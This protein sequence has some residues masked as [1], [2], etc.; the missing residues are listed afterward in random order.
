M[1]VNITQVIYMQL[2]LGKEV[3]FLC[4]GYEIEDVK[5]SQ[6]HTIM[7]S[8]GKGEPEYC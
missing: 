8:G 2:M 1:T 3:I 5:A 4:S 7:L 6:K